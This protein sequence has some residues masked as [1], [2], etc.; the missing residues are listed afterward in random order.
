MS[1]SQSKIHLRKGRLGGWSHTPGRPRKDRTFASWGSPDADYHWRNQPHLGWTVN[2]SLVLFPSK[3]QCQHKTGGGL[4]SSAAQG[5]SP[6]N[7][8]AWL[9]RQREEEVVVQNMSDHSLGHR[10]R[11]PQVPSNTTRQWFHGGFIVIKQM[12]NKGIINY[13]GGN[14]S[15]PVVG[16]RNTGEALW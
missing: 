6:V 11:V 3:R 8:T 1:F 16:Y 5:H 13:I 10:S 9:P 12:K 14:I 7:S 2:T 4:W 15:C